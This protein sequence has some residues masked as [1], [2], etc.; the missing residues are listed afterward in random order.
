LEP[1][2]L[3]AC[4]PEKRELNSRPALTI[5]PD[6]TIKPDLT[7]RAERESGGPEAA[8]VIF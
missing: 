8:E 4:D 1:C 6:P 2:H 3:F 5:K 7:I